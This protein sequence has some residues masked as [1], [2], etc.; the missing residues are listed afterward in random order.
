MEHGQVKGGVP[1]IRR[2]LIGQKHNCCALSI[3]EYDFA[4]E[5]EGQERARWWWHL[6][7]GGTARRD[8]I[9]PLS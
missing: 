1:G 2:L 8:G 6:D 3:T 4:R 5:M 7:I 9:V